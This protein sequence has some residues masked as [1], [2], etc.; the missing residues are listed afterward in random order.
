MN[1]YLTTTNNLPIFTS[2]IAEFDQ[3]SLPNPGI[4]QALDDLLLH[5]VQQDLSNHFTENDASNSDKSF[6]EDF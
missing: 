3:H 1:H 5:K 6:G 2:K 4:V